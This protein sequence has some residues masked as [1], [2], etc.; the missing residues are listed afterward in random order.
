MQILRSMRA[1]LKKYTF[2]KGTCLP[3][4]FFS[5][6]H[7][8]LPSCSRHP[9]S[10]SLGLAI[11]PFAPAPDFQVTRQAGF[12]GIT[13]C[14]LG[15]SDLDTR[16]KR[17]SGFIQVSALGQIGKLTLAALIQLLSRIIMGRGLYQ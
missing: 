8:L 12:V 16:T 17:P 10:V 9:L 14:Y 15:A 3:F 5:F 6:I 13:F 11:V 2:L 1:S 4:L 7:P